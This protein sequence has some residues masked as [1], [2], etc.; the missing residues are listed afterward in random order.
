LNK[1]DINQQE[2]ASA[3]IV[4][5]SGDL[6]RRKVIPA[7]FALF[8]QGLLP[9]HFRLFGFARTAMT[10]AAFRDAVAR[11]LLCRYVP[12]Q[13]CA[14]FM[15]DFLSRC[16]YSSGQYGSA[17]SMIDL[18]HLMRER[19]TTRRPNR[20]FYLAVP[21]SVFLDVARAIAAV[22]LVECG[23]ESP[24]SRVVV[25]KPFGRDRASSDTLVRELGR[26]F[27][28]K[29]TY[30]I[31]HYLGKEVVQNLLV[32][33]FG[34]ALFET[35]WRGGSI[36]RIDIEWTEDLSLA[37]R[38]GYFDEFGIVRDVVQNH[39]LQLLAL[40]TMERPASLQANDVRSAKVTALKAVTPLDRGDVVLG[41]YAQGT[42]DGK[43]VPGYLEEDGVPADSTSPTYFSGRFRI[44][45][46]RWKDV[47]I[48]IT[49]GKGLNKGLFSKANWK[50]R[51]DR[52]TRR[53]R[54]MSRGTPATLWGDQAHG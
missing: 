7:L 45:S 33:R 12:G 8:S 36:E 1:S 47:P 26:V 39:L 37:G 49:A 28:E 29:H 18:F 51:G 13:R 44:E 20:L 17:D 10:H 35:V 23:S 50:R 6:A 34:N 31:D 14:E 21:P 42:L 46:E 9:P 41:Q 25:E 43:P 19:E 27:A 4:G 54:P 22:G 3:V 40:V 53:R 11:H 30:R 15:D 24:W 5:A 52:C 32:L 38:A 48:V 2:P 16:F